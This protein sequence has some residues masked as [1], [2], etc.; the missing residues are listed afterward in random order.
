ML[1]RNRLL[2]AIQTAF[3]SHRIA[4]HAQNLHSTYCICNH[5]KN[6]HSVNV[7]LTFAVYTR[8]SSSDIY[9]FSPTVS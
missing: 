7:L 6:L 2:S 8:F 9:I 3:D 1:T 5:Q 4:S